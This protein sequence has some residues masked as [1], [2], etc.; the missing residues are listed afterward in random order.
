M[1]ML[2]LRL[3]RIALLVTAGLVAT[4]GTPSWAQALPGGPPR[5]SLPCELVDTLDWA[6][7]KLRVPANWI[8]TL[9][10]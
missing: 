10:M 9:L 4:G 1:K 3:A 7:F 2:N 8:G 5:V 6:Q